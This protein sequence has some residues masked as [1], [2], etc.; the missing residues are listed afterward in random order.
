MSV[1]RDENARFDV[2][3]LISGRHDLRQRCAEA[4][5]AAHPVASAH[6]PGIVAAHALEQEN[7]H[8]IGERHR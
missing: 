1:L 6:E 4:H 3:F 5:H 2:K 7:A 8:R